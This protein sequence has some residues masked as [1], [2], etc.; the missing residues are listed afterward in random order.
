MA[1]YNGLK[2]AELKELLKERNIPATGMTRKQQYI[3]ALEAQDAQDGGE[4]GDSTDQQEPAVA[5][6]GAI[7]DN[8]E[9]RDDGA[10]ANGKQ[11]ADNATEE[12][13]DQD[14]APVASDLKP[15]DTIT[16]QAGSPAPEDQSDSRKRKRRSP[17]PPVNEEAMQKKLKSADEEE[18]AKLPEDFE[19]DAPAPVDGKA[20]ET[21]RPTGVSDDVMDVTGQEVRDADIEKSVQEPISAAERR[22]ESADPMAV[23]SSIPSDHD[24][25][26]PPSKHA[27]TSAL[28]VGNLLRPL[29]VPPFRDHLISL[30]TP[31][32]EPLDDSL[33]ETIH[34]DT[35]K[36][37]AFVIFTSTEA[38]ARARAGLHDRIW[39]EETQRKALW[40]DFV[41]PRRADEWIATELDAGKSKRFDVVYSADEPGQATASLQEVSQQPPP[42]QSHAQ[43]PSVPGPGMP[44]AP[45]GPRGDR[46]SGAAPTGPRKPHNVPESFSHFASTT[47]LPKLYYQPAHPDLVDKRLDELDRETSR[48]WDGGRQKP[49]G[50]ALD[51]LRRYTFEDGDVIVDGGV[52]FGGFGRDRGAGGQGGGGGG[53]RRGGGGGG[54]RR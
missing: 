41:P 52:D 32:N 47:A 24:A 40:V 50:S 5:E 28:Y 21:V 12:P 38:A 11:D 29:Q 43:A 53:R 18:V 10:N 13:A 54:R 14:S 22:E 30:A 51:Q 33:I 48:D 6:P 31:P 46:P 36:S 45:T 16:P 15:A 19:G 9:P 39:P 35:F 25:A 2:A 27:P 17:T 7:D 26:G 4:A 20:E 8:A 3:E 23:D 42:A 44:N 34:L 1:D 49:L 37:H